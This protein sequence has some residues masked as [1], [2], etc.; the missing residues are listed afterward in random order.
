M[1]ANGMNLAGLHG[2]LSNVH[3]VELSTS[4]DVTRGVKLHADMDLV[5]MA[6]WALRALRRNPRPNL[7]YECRFSQVPSWYPPCPGPNDHDP[8]TIGDT[9]I[10][11]DWEFGY[12]KDM[13]GDTSAD[14]VA[15]GV[16]KRVLGQQ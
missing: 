1:A 14:E 15:R 9:D 12:M 4:A 6:R 8:I 10:R 3:V 13:T 5:A 7:D 11:M 2:E 16:R